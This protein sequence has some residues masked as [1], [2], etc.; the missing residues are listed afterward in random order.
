[1]MVK[2]QFLSMPQIILSLA[3]GRGIVIHQQRRCHGTH[4]KRDKAQLAPKLATDR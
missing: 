3:V 4:G 2:K 1:M